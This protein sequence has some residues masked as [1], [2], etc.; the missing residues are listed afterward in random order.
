MGSYRDLVVWQKSRRVAKEVYRVTRDFPRVEMF[1][2]V[3]QMR[4]AAV[5]IICNIA[6]GQGRWSP[7]D[8]ANFLYIARG[9]VLELETQVYIAQDL[10]YLAEPQANELLRAIGDVGRMLNGLIRHAKRRAREKPLSS[11]H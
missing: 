1:G 8:Q 10:E 11:E 4:R 3:Q 5:S 2:I 7:R 6:E 9:S